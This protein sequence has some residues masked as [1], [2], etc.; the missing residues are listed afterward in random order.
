MR[1]QGKVEWGRSRWPESKE[2][3]D[4][5]VRSGWRGSSVRS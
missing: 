1:S 5:T 4:V 3:T 2:D